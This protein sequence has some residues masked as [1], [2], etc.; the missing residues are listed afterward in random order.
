MKVYQELSL[1]I[2][3]L[4]KSDVITASGDDEIVTFQPDWLDKFGGFGE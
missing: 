1:K 4:D 3:L 2:V